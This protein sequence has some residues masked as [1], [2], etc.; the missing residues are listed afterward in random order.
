MRKLQTHLRPECCLQVGCLDTEGTLIVSWRRQSFV[1]KSTC[2]AIDV[3]RRTIEIACTRCHGKVSIVTLDWR[4]AFGSIN[5]DS[6][7][8]AL[9]RF[10]LPSAFISII[11][12]LMRHRS[13]FVREEGVQSFR[14]PHLSGISQGCMLSSPARCCSSSS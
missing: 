11:S 6:L 13:F 10:G 12:A 8:D 1:E 5:F 9:L 3:A 14:R 2:D 7:L 4:R